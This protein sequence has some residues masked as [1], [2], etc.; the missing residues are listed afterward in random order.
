[1]IFP[2]AADDLL[3]TTSLPSTEGTELDYRP[4]PLRPGQEVRLTVL[5]TVVGPLMLV[6]LGGFAEW[7]RSLGAWVDAVGVAVA[8]A[9]M[10]WWGLGE[11]VGARQRTVPI[12]S[13]LLSASG[14]TS[15]LLAWSKTSVEHSTCFVLAIAWA[16]SC[17]VSRQAASWILADPL[18]DP[19]TRKRWEVNLPSLPPSGLSFDCPP[20]LSY[21]FLPLAI[22]PACLASM[23]LAFVYGGGFWLW[24]VWFVGLLHAT[25]FGWAMA[26]LPLAPW[27]NPIGAWRS[28]LTALSTFVCYD[29]HLTPAAGVFR[30]RTRWLRPAPV[31]WFS[32]V[33]VVFGLSACCYASCPTPQEG[34]QSGGLY[35]S[36]ACWNVV[37]SGVM[38]PTMLLTVLWFVAGAVLHCFEVD[39]VGSS[40]ASNEWDTLVDRLVNSDD[41]LERQHYLLGTTLQGD[42]PVLVHRDLFDQHAHILGDTGASKTS[43][44]IAPIATQLIAHGDSTSVVVDLKG[45]RALFE[46]CRREAQ[47]AGLP[48]R[49]VSNEVGASTFGF[50]PFVQSHNAQMTHSQLVQEILQGLSLDYGIQ[51]GAGYYT[52]MNEIVLNLIL[53]HSGVRSFRE[54]NGFLQEPDWYEQFG[55][56]KDWEAARHLGALVNRLADCDLLNLTPQDCAGHPEVHSNAIDAVELFEEPQVVYL[57]LRSSVDPAG[58]ASVARLFLWAL[59]SAASHRGSF[60]NRVYVF[61]DEFQQV[62]SDGVRQIFEQFRGLGGTLIAAHQTAGQLSRQGTD[63]SAT[64]E[65][66]SAM[67][68]VFRASSLEALEQIEQ[69]AGTKRAKA[70]MWAQPYEWGG[71][72][73]VGRFGPIHA[74]HGSVRVREEDRPRLDRRT[75]Q[76]ISSHR[77]SSL[78]RFTLGS[79]YTQFAG[80]TV[81]IRS[82]FMMSYEEYQRRE[83]AAWPEA[84]GAFPVRRS[85]SAT[86]PINPSIVEVPPPDMSFVEEFERRATEWPDA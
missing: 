64:V 83:R 69:L 7:A 61:L 56:K 40:I 22:V 30:F 11:V 57:S 52:A 54:L 62:I 14:I 33:A 12:A 48:F 39:L 51:Y 47:R 76:A 77:Q 68:Q 59:F 15:L 66:C 45:D 17:L 25:W 43:L 26:T 78:V 67:K 58:A 4:R 21:A 6:G 72:D 71:G 86:V 50:N 73:L 85:P 84:P 49:W 46:T 31:R 19:E 1:M 38:G 18:I 82:P 63:I 16:T 23:K 24:P 53:K 44:G 8:V 5:V 2:D 35:F 3:D 65:S 9:L 70:P 55:Q 13:A 81:P 41:D 74:E 32:V 28:T 29:P 80:A 79:G 34:Y 27:R 10:V 60:D 20:L 36:Q 42:Y 37:Y 75:L